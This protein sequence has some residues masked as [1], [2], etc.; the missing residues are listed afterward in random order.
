MKNTILLPFLV[1][2]ALNLKAQN[3]Y[4]GGEGNGFGNI[5]ITE[6]TFSLPLIYG[7]GQ[8]IG[9]QSET[10]DE[11]SAS[12]VALIYDGGGSAGNEL[13]VINENT[14]LSLFSIYTGGAA[15]GYG[16]AAMLLDEGLDLPVELSYFKGTKEGNLVR[17]EWRTL[18]EL[19]N[20]FFTVER[21]ADRRN[22]EVLKKIKGAGTS[23]QSLMYT[24][25]DEQPLEGIAYYRLKQTDFDGQYSYSTIVYIS[26]GFEKNEQFV[27]FP[28]PFTDQLTLLLDEKY[29][30]R[31]K[32]FSVE[33]QEINFDVTSSLSDRISIDLGEVSKGVYI[34]KTM[35]KSVLIVKK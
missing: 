23:Y 20:D 9:S 2:L 7:G 35:H 18:T 33:G 30:T 21:S 26:N 4:Q 15:F 19:D 17:L 5:V 6:S 22:W 3:I 13:A 27:A 25:D 10:V 31:L 16:S 24:F 8:G 29:H 14:P 11:G 12:G 1:L 28:N 32:V 34:V